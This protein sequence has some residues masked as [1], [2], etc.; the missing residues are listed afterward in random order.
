MNGAHKLQASTVKNPIF[1]ENFGKIIHFYSVKLPVRQI[2]S[3]IMNGILLHK[4]RHGQFDGE[5]IKRHGFGFHHQTEVEK[6]FVKNFHIITLQG[7][8][9][10]RIS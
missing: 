10:K 4:G 2:L 3:S 7:K 8:T 9:Q 5:I 6:S 1:T